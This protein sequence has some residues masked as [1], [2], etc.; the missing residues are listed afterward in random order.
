MRM[1]LKS[2]EDE[3]VAEIK[4]EIAP[5]KDDVIHVERGLDRRTFTI[6]SREWVFFHDSGEQAAEL[7]GLERK[8]PRPAERID[9][10]RYQKVL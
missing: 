10:A 4:G 5:A 7:V 2:S 9:P 6:Q 8:A 1:L 3:L